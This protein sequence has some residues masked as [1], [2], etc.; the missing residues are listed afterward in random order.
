MAKLARMFASE[1]SFDLIARRFIDA[2]NRRDV[3]S[4]IALSD[5]AIEFHPS[6]L[7]GRRQRYDGHDGLRRWVEEL[8]KSGLEHQVQVRQVRPSDDGFVILAEVLIDGTA[9]TPGT[10]VARVNERHEIAEAH[11]FLTDAEL[12]AR[13]GVMPGDSLHTA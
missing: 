9:V 12:L 8:G 11:V 3:E 1:I 10:M 6:S 4:L 13:I 7:V 2:F 5:P